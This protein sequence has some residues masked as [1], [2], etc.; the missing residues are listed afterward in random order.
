MERRMVHLSRTFADAHA[1]ASRR[2]SQP[3]VLRIEAKTA[4]RAGV[5]FYHE[6]H[7]FLATHIPPQFLAVEP[8]H[9]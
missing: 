3:V 4:H 6:G 8:E 7:L 5:A 9:P 1:V 2:T